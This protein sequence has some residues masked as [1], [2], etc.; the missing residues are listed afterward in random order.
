MVNHANKVLC[1]T[2]NYSYKEQLRSLFSYR[3]TTSILCIHNLSDAMMK[4]QSENY[5]I[6]IDD[7]ISQNNEVLF[8]QLLELITSL[9][10]STNTLIIVPQLNKEY[11]YKYLKLGFTYVTDIQIANNL[12]PA[13]LKHMEEF[14]FK[15]PSPKKIYYKGLVIYPQLNIVTL[16]SCRVLI[17]PVGMLILMF[18]IKHGGYCDIDTIQRYIKFALGKTISQ[19]YATVNIHRL[20]K[21]ITAATG[22]RII[23]CRYGVGYYLVL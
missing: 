4:I 15:R 23:K 3:N 8:K 19:S 13:V 1:I 12:L 11:F 21:S 7:L 20:S 10:I 6:I 22:L 17:T 14:Q 9:C 16:K 18:M 2:N 5:F